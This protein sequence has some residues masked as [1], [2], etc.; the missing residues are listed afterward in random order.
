MTSATVSLDTIADDLTKEAIRKEQLVPDGRFIV[1]NSSR[2]A[3]GR[4]NKANNAGNAVVV[5]S[6]GAGVGHVSFMADAFWAGALC[7]PLRSKNEQTVMTRYL[8][9]ILK[10]REGF[11]A[12]TLASKGGI[13]YVNRKTLNKMRLCI[14]PLP[15]QH[16]VVSMLDRLD[17]YVN[18]LS[19]GLPAE[20][21]ARQKQYE[22]WRD[23]LLA[24]RQ[25]TPTTLG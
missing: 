4:Y 21:E 14:P 16:I 20:I 25:Q 7:H 13:P 15:I 12:D 9:Y 3:Y 23:R 17:S 8:F 19:S 1:M 5:A 24:F 6:H 11:I 10:Q 18:G 2:N 22:W